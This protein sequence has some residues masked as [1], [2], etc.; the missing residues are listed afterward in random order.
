MLMILIH[1]V[2]G[3]LYLVFLCHPQFV[4]EEIKDWFMLMCLASAVFVDSLDLLRF[5]TTDRIMSGAEIRIGVNTLMKWGWG[6]RP[7]AASA[8]WASPDRSEP[9]T[10][11]V[12][13][14]LCCW[15]ASV[16]H[17]N[18]LPLIWSLFLDTF[19]NTFWHLTHMCATSTHSHETLPKAA[20]FQVFISYWLNYCTSY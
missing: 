1:I 17:A 9:D 11:E 15:H 18:L 14:E 10:E 19:F 4:G 16:Y 8:V 3:Y 20:L 13:R 7:W 12:R 6:V 5:R 2:I